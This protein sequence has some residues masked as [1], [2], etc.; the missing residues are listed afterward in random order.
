MRRIPYTGGLI[1]VGREG[2]FLRL[3]IA[4]SA[5]RQHGV[6]FLFQFAEL[7]PAF[8]LWKIVTTARRHV[9]H[10]QAIFR[11][12]GLQALK[13][14]RQSRRPGKRARRRIERKHLSK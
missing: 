1:G 5:R 13:L 9:G 6:A 14:A 12:R 8:G 3:R 11:E 2:D 10:A 7:T 4:Q